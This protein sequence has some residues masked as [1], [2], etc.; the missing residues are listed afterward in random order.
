MQLGATH[1]P[2]NAAHI[3]VARHRSVVSTGITVTL[4]S[5]AAEATADTA[6]GVGD[7]QNA[8]V[9]HGG[10]SFE[11]DDA[12][13]ARTHNAA[14]IHYA[15]GAIIVPMSVG[16]DYGRIAVAITND[17]RNM[18]VGLFVRV[19]IGIVA[20]ETADAADKLVRQIHFEGDLAVSYGVKLQLSMEVLSADATHTL[21]CSLFLTRIVYGEMLGYTAADNATV[22][23]CADTTDVVEEGFA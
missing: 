5:F 6:H 14:D 16:V 19:F 2:H 8:A 20:A 12:S 15:F 13:L 10:A 9:F 11:L 22:V 17:R 3:V 7:S 1:K 23:E 21:Q 18:G 4:A